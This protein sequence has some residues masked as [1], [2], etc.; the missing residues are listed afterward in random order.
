MR[1][2]RIIEESNALLSVIDEDQGISE[3]EKLFDDW[4]NVQF[5]HNFFETHQKDL[6]GYG[7]EEAVNRTIE[8]AFSLE[9]KFYEIVED[10][11]DELQ[12]LFR[13]LSNSQY[14]IRKFQREKSSGL[15]RK[16]WLRVYAIRI[17]SNKYLIT[18]GAIKLTQKMQ[19]RSHTNEQLVR[20]TQARDFLLENGFLDTDIEMLEV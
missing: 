17:E 6:E 13:P 11:I 7:I 1:I 2:V 16:S 3:F 5:L 8:D 15:F 14:K 9:D 20:L 4:T 18:G 12:I 10:E 19:E